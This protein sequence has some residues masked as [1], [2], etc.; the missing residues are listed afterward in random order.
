MVTHL[1][2]YL[3]MDHFIFKV[4]TLDIPDTTFNP[5]LSHHSRL[6]PLPPFP[7]Y[8]HQCDPVPLFCPPAVPGV[9]PTVFPGGRQHQPVHSGGHA[10]LHPVHH[11]PGLPA[12]PGPPGGRAP[13]VRPLAALGMCSGQTPVWF[14]VHIVCHF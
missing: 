3:K 5:S 2:I 1:R 12:D 8:P 6:L 11:A 10:L 7:S 13:Q 4:L 14:R 9:P